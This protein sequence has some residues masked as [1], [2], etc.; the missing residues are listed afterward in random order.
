MENTIDKPCGTIPPLSDVTSMHRGR[1][2]PP[3]KSFAETGRRR[4]RHVETSAVS[5]FY[6]KLISPSSTQTTELDPT[7]MAHADK[8][9]VLPDM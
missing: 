7:E 3:S 4:L 2:S 8:E 9:Q 5:K 6:E 1:C